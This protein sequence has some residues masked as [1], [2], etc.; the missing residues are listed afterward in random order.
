MPVRF[1][2]TLFFLGLSSLARAQSDLSV[3]EVTRRVLESANSYARAIACETAEATAKDVAALVPLGPATDNA[4][5][6]EG[7]CAVLWHGDIG[8]RGGSGTVTDNIALVVRMADDTFLVDP[9]ASSPQIAFDTS[10]ATID[11]LV[12]ATKD[13]LVLDGRRYCDGQWSLASCAVKVR[14]TLQQAKGGTWKVVGTRD[15]K[16]R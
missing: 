16:S 6:G 4:P 14:I 12:G 10:I 7:T 15:L 11:R 1:L 2:F 5:Y 8:C 13:S 9:R 3:A